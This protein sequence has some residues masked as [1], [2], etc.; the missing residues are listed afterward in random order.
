MELR[1]IHNFSPYMKILVDPQTY[2]E[3]KFGGISRYHTELYLEYQK[4]K[5][6]QI[7]CPIL[8]SDN[9]HL[10]EASLFQSFRNT[11][12]ESKLIPKFIRKKII[13]LYKKKNINATIE[14]L[15]EGN[16]DVLMPTYYNPYFL[17]KLNGKPYVLTLHDMI[18]ELFPHYFTR[19]LH[20]VKNKKLLL[21]NATK[22]IAVS[23]NTKKDILKIYPHIDSTKIE[24]VY[25]SHSVKT[26]QNAKVNLPKEYV[27]FVGNRKNYKNFIFF[28]NAV[29]PILKA[30][31]KLFVVAAGGNKF[32]KDEQQLIRKLGVSNQI[33]HQNFEDLELAA[34]YSQAKCFVFP[35]EYEGF[36]I[37]VLESMACGC[38]IVLANHS[39]FPEVAGEAGVYFELNNESD[40]KNKILKLIE[41]NDFRVKHIQMGLQQAQKFSWKK[42][43][44]ECLDVYKK[45]IV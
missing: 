25:L 42:T 43:A 30:Y 19:D 44:S 8:F 22:V 23:Q 41:D 1:A 10:K 24:V 45:A 2:N 37:P 27:L 36:G 33:L 17:E 40:L 11:I 6:I 34:Y 18:H 28:L 3:Q 5:D 21:E 38:P 32:T 15:E 31:P 9:L 13:K 14:A 4:T 39:S 20:T 16:F 35:S 29:A 26:T 7:I 12:F